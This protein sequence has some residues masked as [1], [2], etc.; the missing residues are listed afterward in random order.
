MIPQNRRTFLR[1]LS[2]GAIGLGTLV[3]LPGCSQRPSELPDTGVGTLVRST[4][5]EQGIPSS[6]IIHTLNAIQESGIG[7]HSLMILRHGHVVAEAW[8]RPYAKGLKHSLYS[9][10]KSFTSTAIGIAVDEGL[11]SVDY[12]VVSFFPEDLPAK[13][14]YNLGALKIKH[15]LSMSVGREKDSLPP[16]RSTNES[17]ARTFLQM[18]IEHESR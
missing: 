11:L 6:A 12:P 7:F 5:E 1:E 17:W 3:Y 2:A 14:N 4:P 8:W 18:H 10:S 9:L 13:V 15:L 16:M